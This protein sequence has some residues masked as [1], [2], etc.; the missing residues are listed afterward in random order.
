MRRLSLLFALFVCTAAVSWAQDPLDGA[1]WG[2]YARDISGKV[3]GARSENT[4]MVPASNIKLITTGAA[5]HALGPDFRFR[6]GIGYSGQIGPDGTLEGD[7]YIMGGGDPTIGAKDSLALRADALFWKWK[8]ILKSNGIERIHGRIIGDGSSWEGGLEHIEWSYSDIATYYGT[9]VNGLCFY[10]N[11]IDVTVSP[12][13]EGEPVAM[14]QTYP[15]TPWMNV[16]NYSVT[17]PA[18]S[19]NSLYMFTTDLAPYAELRG[20]FGLDRAPKV[21]NASNKYGDLT[22]AYYFWKNLRDT[23]WEVT[24]GYARVDRG[25]Y[26]CGPDFVPQDKASAPVQLG[27]TESPALKDI[28]RIANRRSDNFYAESIFRAMG[29]VS[30]GIASYDS[31]LVALNVVL[32]DLGANPSKAVIVDGS[33]LSRK[34]AVSPK[35]MVDYLDAMRG[36]SAFPAFIATLPAPGEGT[37]SVVRVP[38]GVS[39][40]MKSGSMEGVMCYSGYILDGTGSPAVVFSAFATNANASSSALRAALIQKISKFAP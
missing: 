35:W 23:G 22:C 24:G 11:A 7:V 36:S 4:R 29:E 37:L 15:E 19:G 26:V 25:G 21:E 2:I 28:A 39:V 1:A 8:T 17:G 31:S 20:T 16:S 27:F 3:L 40:K 32:E 13:K 38:E 14:N 18:G 12:T 9:G 33:G 6:T 34:N 30:S 5:L 10:E